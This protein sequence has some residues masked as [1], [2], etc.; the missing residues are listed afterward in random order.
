MHYLT[1]PSGS[2]TFKLPFN[3]SLNSNIVH[4][5]PIS[6]RVQEIQYLPPVLIFTAHFLWPVHSTQKVVGS[7]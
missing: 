5:E 4:L 2:Q 3:L 1:L 6:S 7:L